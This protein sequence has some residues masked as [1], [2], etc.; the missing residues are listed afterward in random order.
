MKESLLDALIKF[1]LSRYDGHVNA[2]CSPKLIAFFQNIYV[3]NP[4]FYK[5][6]SQNF[7][8]YHERTLRKFEAVESAEVPIVNCSDEMNKTRPR[9]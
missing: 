9:I 7:G 1:T 3:L 8:G 2:P 4:K 5:I 6:F